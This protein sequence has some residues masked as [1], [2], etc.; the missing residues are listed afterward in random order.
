MDVPH[1]PEKT[2]QLLSYIEQTELKS[3]GLGQLFCGGTIAAILSNDDRVE[4]LFQSILEW[5]G[6]AGSGRTGNHSRFGHLLDLARN[7][8]A[9]NATAGD[10]LTFQPGFVVNLSRKFL[11]YESTVNRSLQAFP[12]AFCLGDQRTWVPY[13]AVQL[14]WNLMSDIFASVL[15]KKHIPF[16]VQVE[17]LI[18]PISYSEISSISD[19]LSNSSGRWQRLAYQIEKHRNEASGVFDKRIIREL[20]AVATLVPAIQRLICLL[21]DKILSSTNSVPKDHYLLNRPHCDG[22]K[23][24]TAVLGS[25]DNVRTDVLGLRQWIRLPI[26][27]STLAIFPSPKLNSHTGIAPTVHRVLLE[28]NAEKTEFAKQ[29]VTLSL[30]IVDRPRECWSKAYLDAERQ[31]PV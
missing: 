28:Q 5:L 16:A 20:Y 9:G 6:L 22:G 14:V 18:Y 15:P 2:K 12:N 7:H 1:T 21:N 19:F 13:E 23:Y 27:V 25:R 30:S 31:A 4:R 3:G 10:M 11:V 8:S 29:N 24:V 26:S 17:C